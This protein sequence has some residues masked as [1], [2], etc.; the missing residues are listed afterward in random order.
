MALKSLLQTLR[1]LNRATDTLARLN[2]THRPESS[3]DPFAMS[4]VKDA[5]PESGGPIAVAEC[6]KG[7]ST[8]VPQLPTQLDGLEWR[9]ANALFETQLALSQAYCLRGSVRE[10]E[11]FEQQA[12]ELARVLGSSAMSL[13]A[14]LQKSELQMS[15]RNL[16]DAEKT[17]E[18]ATQLARDPRGLH[19]VDVHRA[20]GERLIL[21]SQEE[22][23]QGR[24]DQA[25]GVLAKE[26]KNFDVLDKLVPNRSNSEIEDVFA[27]VAQAKILRQKGELSCP[28]GKTG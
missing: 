2:T 9:I 18:A 16:G 17:L 13:R 22:E 21:C 1:L 6:G 3:S 15:L 12:E 4:D 14:L 26:T 24:L 25:A 20:V 7:D 11:Y 23:A 5:L 19:A 8:R 28:F 27:P 10:A